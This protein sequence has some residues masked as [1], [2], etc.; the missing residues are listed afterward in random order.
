MQWMRVQALGGL[1]EAAAAYWDAIA[2]RLE[3]EDWLVRCAAIK[4]S[5][6]VVLPYAPVL[7]ISRQHR[8]VCVGAMS[9]CCCVLSGINAWGGRGLGGMMVVGGRMSGHL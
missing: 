4:V 3:D 6:T 5:G 1:G 2:A 7:S 8:H 9:C